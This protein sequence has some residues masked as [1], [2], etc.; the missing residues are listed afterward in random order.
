M[1]TNNAKLSNKLYDELVRSLHKNK[2]SHRIFSGSDGS[3]FRDGDRLGKRVRELDDGGRFT[4]VPRQ[5][6][7]ENKR[8]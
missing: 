3:E 5:R 8:R 2:H 4:K 6:G 7:G 1:T